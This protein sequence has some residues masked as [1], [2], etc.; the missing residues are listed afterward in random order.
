MMNPASWGRRA[1]VAALVVGCLA[2]PASATEPVEH[3][4][5]RLAALSP[6]DTTS[7]PAVHELQMKLIELTEMSLMWE[8]AA[9]V[10]ACHDL[11]AATVSQVPERYRGFVSLV[12]AALAEMLVT[13][14]DQPERGI[15]H[16]EFARSQLES[17]RGDGRFGD[18]D[19]LAPDYFIREHGLA[20]FMHRADASHEPEEVAG[21]LQRCRSLYAEQDVLLDQYQERFGESLVPDRRRRRDLTDPDWLDLRTDGTEP[22][23]WTDEQ[24]SAY[25][26]GFRE[27]RSEA[28][29][30]DLALVWFG[31]Q[32]DDLE[33][34]RADWG[35]TPF[36]FVAVTSTN[37]DWGAELLVP[38][39]R[40]TDLRRSVSAEL[41]KHIGHDFV[42]TRSLSGDVLQDRRIPGTQDMESAD[43]PAR[44]AYPKLLELF[45]PDYSESARRRKA[46]GTVMVKVL[47]GTDGRV[48]TAEVVKGVDEELDA[49]GLEAA[50][51]ARFEPA[52]Q[53]GVPVEAWMM[54][55]YRFRLTDMDEA[56]GE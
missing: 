18:L 13:R 15:R 51:K 6:V 19:F 46:E 8:D 17:I 33:A 14:L 38:L 49:A 12:D 47:I 7:A 42:R 41:R 28:T 20:I 44:Q 10:Q 30:L 52:R 27:R 48:L 4:E 32:G 45:P 16:Y 55:P 23:E 56:E 39:F 29:P 11:I 24:W 40:E 53:R 50:F 54:I 1:A 21:L 25:R 36:P 3:I 5:A 9:D 34:A 26:N 2:G 43:D 22:G 35:G 37:P 31:D